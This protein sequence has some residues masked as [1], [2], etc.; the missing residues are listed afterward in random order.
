MTSANSPKQSVPRTQSRT[1]LFKLI[2]VCLFSAVMAAGGYVLYQ[3]Y[4][5]KS[6]SLTTAQITA[7]A[8]TTSSDDRQA[9]L[10]LSRGALAAESVHQIAPPVEPRNNLGEVSRV[11]LGYQLF[12]DPILSGDQTTACASCHHPDYGMA[13]GLPKA[14]GVGGRGYG[15]QRAGTGRE[16]S[17]NTPSL[18]NV[19]FNALQFWD[20]RVGTLE[21]QVMIPLFEETEM[22]QQ[23]PAELLKRLR[24]IP[25]YRE[26]FAKAFGFKSKQDGSEVTLQNI[27]RAIAAFERKLNITN[28]AYDKFVEGKDDAMTTDQLRGMVVF[29]G[30]AN[31]II[32]H[33]PPHFHDGVLSSIGTTT[34]A[35]KNA[36]LDDDPGFAAVMRREDGFGMF[37]TPGL[38][39]VERTAPYMHNGAFKTLEEVVEFYNDGG[40]RGRGKDAFAQDSKVAKLDLSEQQKKDLVAFLKSLNSL[41]PPPIVPE[42]VPSGL[43]VAGK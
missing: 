11:E 13:D 12:F 24:A 9:W 22:K 26:L 23:S 25:R 19:A 27:T 41:S 6:A 7:L 3:H 10:R 40:G 21:E 2:V 43:P 4:S 15:M 34:S 36:P 29:F 33:I 1:R 31:C 16:L 28:T 30:Q 42:S 5:A 18:F 35:D 14:V 38:R 37:K 32:C 8:K 20:G 17:R 39:N